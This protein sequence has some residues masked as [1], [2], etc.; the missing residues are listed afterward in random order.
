[1][2]LFCVNL[3]DEAKKKRG[4]EI[5]LEEL[6]E[7]LGVSVIGITARKKIDLE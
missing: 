4:V 5:D 2:L 7:L 1:M 6:E 3:L